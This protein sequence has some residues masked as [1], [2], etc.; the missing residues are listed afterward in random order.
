MTA[1]TATCDSF[2]V[3]L[4]TDCFRTRPCGPVSPANLPRTEVKNE[5]TPEAHQTLGKLDKV[6]KNE[7]LPDHLELSITGGPGPSIASLIGL[8]AA[9]EGVQLPLAM[10]GAGTRRLSALAIAEQ[11]QGDAPITLVDEIERG[12]EP[13]RQRALT[14]RLQKSQSQVFATT[15]SPFVLA[16]AGTL[17]SGTW[18]TTAGSAPSTE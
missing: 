9:R 16:A 3:P 18:I 7:K 2:R 1:T 4:W 12:L 6:F 13:Y 15:H 11:K 8:T 10:W 5:L 14:A 17:R